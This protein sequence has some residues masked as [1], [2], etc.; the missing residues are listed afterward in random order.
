MDFF[1]RHKALIITSLLFAVLMLALYNFN[2][3]SNNKATAE[4]LVDLEQYKLEQQEEPEPEKQEETPPENRRN[5]QT[6]QAY[7]Q[8]RETREADFKNKLN[9]IFEKNSAEQEEAENENTESSAGNYS[10][11]RKNSEEKKKLSDGDNSAKQTSQKSAAYDYSSISFSLKGRNAVKIPNPVYTCDTAGKIVINITVDS[12]GYVIDTSVNRGSSTSGNE[13][14]TDRALEYAAGARFSKLAG[15][16]SQP[17]T[18]TYY[19][20]S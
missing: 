15:R 14:L 16:N 5:V 13:C 20:K 10:L 9:D 19:F 2:L 8:D 17:G 7:N 3:S 18:I 6:H 4:M 12:N 1:D 11:S